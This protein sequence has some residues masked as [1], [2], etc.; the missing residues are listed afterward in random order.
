M[1]FKLFKGMET[2]FASNDEM[3]VHIWS[4]YKQ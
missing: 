4:N 3:M 1:E 2:Q